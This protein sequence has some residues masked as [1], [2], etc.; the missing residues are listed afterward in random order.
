MI[1]VILIAFTLIAFAANSLLCRM[2]LGGDHIDPSRE[3]CNNAG[4]AGK[5]GGILFAST[6]ACLSSP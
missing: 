6:Q 4:L 3:L 1:V 5:S 2:A